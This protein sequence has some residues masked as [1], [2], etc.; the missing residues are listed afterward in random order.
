RSLVWS[1]SLGASLVLGAW[2]LVLPQRACAQGSL[3]PPSA[4]AATMKSLD[5]IEPRIDLQNAPASAVTTT[6]ANYHFIITQP[7]SYYLTANIAATKTNAVQI[8]SVGV[9]LDLNGFQIS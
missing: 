5:Q 6:D 8:N 4:P 7:G 3:I 1:V 9:T 2:C